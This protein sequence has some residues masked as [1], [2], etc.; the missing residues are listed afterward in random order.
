MCIL[1]KL[2]ANKNITMVSKYAPG[3]IGNCRCNEYPKYTEASHVQWP[4]GHEFLLH[5]MREV[6]Y[7]FFISSRC[8]KTL[9]GGNLDFHKVK[10]LK[11]FVLMNEH[12]QKCE[13][14]AI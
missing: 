5:R 8:Y 1:L 3:G 12:A 14:N 11:K 4:N 7:Y 10:K 9:Y 2:T 13:N 6:R